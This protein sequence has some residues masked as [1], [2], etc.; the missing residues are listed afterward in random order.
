[1]V[2][3]KCGSPLLDSFAPSLSVKVLDGVIHAMMREE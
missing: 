1:M 2:V 3:K